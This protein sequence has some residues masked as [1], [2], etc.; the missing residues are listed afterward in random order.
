MLDAN[1]IQNIK[2]NMTNSGHRYVDGEGMLSGPIV[3][4]KTFFMGG[5]QGFYENIPFPK[6]ATV[7]TDLQRIGDFAQTFNSNGQHVTIYDPLTTTCN[8]AGQCTRQAFP[9]NKIPLARMNPVAVALL[10]RIPRE[11]AAA[12]SPTG[13]NDYFN[14]PNLGFYRYNSYLMRFDH[15]V[16]DRQ[17]LSFSNSGNWGYE[18]RNE[19]G[20]PL[21]LNHPFVD[22]NKRVAAHAAILFVELNGQTFL[23]TPGEV[24]E[25]TLAVAEGKVAV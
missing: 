16:S 8:A 7:P 10:Q 6:S 14:S 12:T 21:V 4:G 18:R 13:T 25:M 20:L 22:G 19:N 5:Y 9:G 1:Q 17:R 24:V 3:R 11:N 15:Y 23:A 2:H